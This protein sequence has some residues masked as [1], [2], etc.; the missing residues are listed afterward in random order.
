M[1]EKYKQVFLYDEKD[2]GYMACWLPSSGLKEGM[3]ISLKGQTKIWIVGPTN[4]PEMDISLIHTDW[5]CGENGEIAKAPK[6]N[7]R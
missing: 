5:K 4:G 7:F 1:E 2:N 6:S 3:R